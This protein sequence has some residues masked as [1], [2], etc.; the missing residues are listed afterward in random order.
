MTPERRAEI[1][2]EGR[3][4]TVGYQKNSVDSYQSFLVGAVSPRGEPHIN[5]VET[6]VGRFGSQSELARL[7]ETKQS[8]VQYWAATGRIPSKWH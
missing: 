7:L 2:K 4:K 3:R 6:L 8:T 5:R 1:A